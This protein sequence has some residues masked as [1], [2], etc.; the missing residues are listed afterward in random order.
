MKKAMISALILS[1]ATALCAPAV[2]AEE[3]ENKD[4]DKL[5]ALSL[6]SLFNQKVLVA[7]KRPEEVSEA[8]GVISVI[9]SEEI[10]RFGYHNLYDVLERLPNTYQ[11]YAPTLPEGNISMRG[12]DKADANHH[13]LVLFN[14]RPV[15]D[16]IN[17]GL[18]API[19]KMFPVDLIQHIE[20]IRGPGSVLYGTNAFAGVIN[21]VTKG[22]E[23]DGQDATAFGSYGSYKTARYGLVGDVRKDDFFGQVSLLN[24]SSTGWVFDHTDTMGRSDDPRTNGDGNSMYFNLDYQGFTLQG[25]SG[26]TQDMTLEPKFVYPSYDTSQRRTF[27]NAGYDYD[28]G[29][30]TWNVAT[31]LTYNGA[32]ITN[33]ATDYMSDDLLAEVTVGGEIIDNFN[34]VVGGTFE[35]LNTSLKAS[36][37]DGDSTRWSLYSQ[38]DYKPID[39]MKLIAGAQ[40]NHVNSHDADLSPRVGTIINF[41]DHIGFKAMHSKAFRSPTT[42]ELHLVMPMKIGNN[43]LKPETVQTTDLQLFYEDDDAFVALTAY[44]S[45]VKNIIEPVLISDRATNLWQYLNTGDYDYKGIELEGKVKFDDEWMLVGSVS[46]QT[47]DDNLGN[48]HDA[49]TMPN[50]MAKLGVSYAGVDN[51]LTF[52]L[53]E[54]YTGAPDNIADSNPYGYVASNP[55]GH[56]HHNI[57]LN[58]GVNLNTYL[59]IK[60]MPETDLNLYVENLLDQEV[61]YPNFISGSTNTFPLSPGRTVYGKVSIKF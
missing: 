27:L 16:S 17:G 24:E 6:D 44:K 31:N 59:D 43:A 34:A 9:T 56:S 55:E 48:K 47:G 21:I 39:W 8:P 19:F 35:T 61:Y 3:A 10:E 30:S 18:N 36:G 1:A 57:A 29:E 38:L 51:G 23:D 52:G 11:H 37:G 45:R 46:H 50:F 33:S 32:S 41:T 25:F 42:D 22:R 26:H 53:Y 54:Q 15:R 13:T 14:G 20:V 12:M 2:M 58:A 5:L 40:Y 28:I 60:G 7:S 49:G 4:I